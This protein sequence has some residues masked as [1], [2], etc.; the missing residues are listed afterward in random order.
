MDALIIDNSVPFGKLLSFRVLPYGIRGV[1][2]TTRQEA[3]TKLESME[4]VTLFFIDLDNKDIDGQALIKTI[5]S[6]I[7]NSQIVLHTNQSFDSISIN[8][9]D[10]AIKGMLPK[11]FSEDNLNRYLIPLMSRIEFPATEKRKHIRVRPDPNELLRIS[12][13]INNYQGLVHGKVLNL[14]MGGVAIEL[15]KKP[16]NN[17]LVEQRYVY[18]IQFT[19][20]FKPINLKGQIVLSKEN[21]VALRFL[22]YGANLGRV[23]AEYILERIESAA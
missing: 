8:T 23:M 18:N 1:R 9:N 10:P 17:V 7:K 13:R 16:D 2:A 22:P 20:N 15:L 19:L 3:L 21:I 12:F 4:N 14:S 5:K 11:T 6:K